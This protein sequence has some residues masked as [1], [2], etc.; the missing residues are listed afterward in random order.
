[1]HELSHQEN[2]ENVKEGKEREEPSLWVVVTE[3][4]KRNTMLFKTRKKKSFQ[5]FWQ[6][7]K[8]A[9]PLFESSLGKNH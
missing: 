1:M 4:Q 5:R 9:V 6:M 7:T 2:E 3:W 8:E